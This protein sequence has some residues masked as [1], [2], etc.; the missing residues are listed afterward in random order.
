M[1]FQPAVDSYEH[2]I[3][4]R[5]TDRRQV[6]AWSAGAELVVRVKIRDAAA[7][8]AYRSASPQDKQEKF[9]NNGTRVRW[10]TYKPLSSVEG[11]DDI[12]SIKILRPKT[13]QERRNIDSSEQIIIGTA[14]GDLQLLE[15]P[16]ASEGGVIKTY[17]VT[18]GVPVR[19]M[20]LST[21]IESSQNQPQHLAA[22]LSDSK[23]AIYQV[24]S[25]QLK[26][27]PVSEIDAIPQSRKGCRIWSTKFLSPGRLAVG[28]GPSVEPI[29]IFE[30]R[31]EGIVEEPMRRIGL[32]GS[33][34]EPETVRV[35]SIYPIE[36]VLHSNGGRDGNLFLSGGYD[37]IVRLHDM[38]SPAPF[39]AVYHD[40][41]DDAAIYSLL[42]RGRDR[43]VA[44]ASRH[45]LL[46]MFDLRMSGGSIYDY[47]GSSDT[48]DSATGDWN[49]FINP[50]DRY[51][52]ST[53]RGPN[54]WMRRSAEGSVYNLSSPSP[55]SPF[56]FAGV[57]NA[58]V[59]FN[60]SSVLDKHPDPIFL[61]RLD[62]RKGQRAHAPSYLQHKH[63]ILNLAMYSQGTDG[64]REGMKLRTQRSVQETIGLGTN[65]TGLDERWKENH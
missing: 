53:W 65:F 63:D 44:G 17:Y 23:V 58:V 59:E 26:I 60:F 39:T 37:G 55:T 31:P 11:R 56:I 54:S 28:L 41:T 51:V 64:S 62:G 29:N 34:D 21:D 19:S 4:N 15:L 8:D 9:E 30:I 38:R 25:M 20:S 48:N 14:N 1:G 24:D 43:V 32:A 46:K 49:L 57:E 36:P 3:E 2:F 35:S 7:E 33:A 40:P 52:N 10:W 13:Q 6:V 47:A 42:S 22:N 16:P 27:A 5:W 18:N 45:G 50:R 61:E 12:T